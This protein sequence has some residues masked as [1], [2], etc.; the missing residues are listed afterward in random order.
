MFK[1]CIRIITILYI[2]SPPVPAP[3]AMLPELPADESG[4]LALLHETVIDTLQYEQLLVYYALPLSVPQGELALLAQIFP[5]VDLDA[6]LPSPEQLESYRPFDNRQIQRLLND[7]PILAGL[8]PILRFNTSLSAAGT[9]GEVI[10]GINKSGIDELRGHRIRFRI[11]GSPVSAE[12]AA[13]LSD[14]GALWQNRR[15]D[16]TR[17][18]INA[19]IGNFRQPLPG[20][21]F[22]GKFAAIPADERTVEANWLYGGTNTW[23]GAA[24]TVKNIPGVSAVGMSGFYHIR[25]NEKAAGGAVDWRINKQI[26]MYAGLTAFADTNNVNADNTGANIHDS[27]YT[28]NAHLYGEYKGKVWRAAIETGLPLEQENIVPALSCRLHYRIRE[29][30]AQY[31]LLMYPHEFHAPMSRA[32]RQTLAEIGVRESPQSPASAIQK[33]S[34][35]M[36]VP[37]PLPIINTMRLI[38]EIDFTEYHG[39]IRRVQGRAEARA[40]TKNA[41]ISLR[42]AARIFPTGTD[43]VLHTSSATLNLQ[44]N[45]PLSLRATGQRVYG[46]H[47][48][49]RNTYTLEPQYTGL[50]NTLIAPFITGRHIPETKIHEYRLG[51]KTE[52]HLYKKTWTSVTL[53][54]PVN[55]KGENNVYIKGS[56]SYSF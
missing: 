35:R 37:I 15:L 46:T 54:V 56:S 42:H 18:G 11:K 34:L 39:T 20:E 26:K 6:L 21:L 29:S 4:L 45:Y 13:A 9:A 2:L 17:A 49:T 31:H 38:P 33:H 48:N 43:S 24:L 53:E 10:F 50:P 36:T 3:A 41:D 40:R 44:S 14:T 25:A 51:M 28:Y 16:F 19:Q 8:E 5:D 23:N 47:R 22:Y 12:G 30:S 55:A 1:N 32:K 27:T 52:L 7:F